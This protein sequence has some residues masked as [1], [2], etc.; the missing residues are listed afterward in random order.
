MARETVFRG[1]QSE[2]IAGVRNAASFTWSLPVAVIWSARPADIFARRPKAAFLPSSTV[3][4]AEIDVRNP[5]QFDESYISMGEVIQ[6]LDYGKA[7]GIT[8]EE[9][10]RIYNYMHNRITGKAAGGEYKYKVLDLEGN[11]RDEDEVPLSFYAPQSLITLARDDW[12]FD[13]TVDTASHVVADTYIFA[14][15]PAVQKAAKR[16]GYDMMVYPD[17][18]EGGESASKELLGRD[19]KTLDGVKVGYDI[20][21]HR[22]PTHITLRVLDPERII[23][24]IAIPT[25][26]VLAEAK[27]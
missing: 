20:D 15:V 4:M 26:D 19:I 2:N 10:R 9:V 24:I 21:G 1:T 12:D 18:F 23:D 7:D 13:P 16:L 14:D 25:A 27:L 3:H 22:V 11:D 8:E 5:L 17:V 6:A